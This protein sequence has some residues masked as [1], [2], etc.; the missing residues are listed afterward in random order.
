MKIAP[1]L[2]MIA[3]VAAAQDVLVVDPLGS[4]D[5]LTIASAYAA[6]SPGDVLLVRGGTY[7]G[8][9]IDR[10]VTIVAEEGTSVSWSGPVHVVADQRVVLS[11]LTFL[12]GLE[13]SDTTAGVRVQESQLLVT[14][15]SGQEAARVVRS[16]DV[17]FTRCS[18]LG[19][20]G[21]T[22]SGSDGDGEEGGEGLRVVGP[23]ARVGLY[24]CT[25][26]GG[27]GGD[28]GPGGL[29]ASALGGYGGA[30][31]QVFNGAELYAMGGEVIGG[32][33][34][35][36]F[37]GGE[38]GPGGV[39]LAVLGD[40]AHV[41]NTWLEG[42]SGGAHDPP[43][44][45]AADGAAHEGPIDFLGTQRREILAPRLVRAGETSTWTLVGRPGDVASSRPRSSRSGAT[46][47]WR[48]ASRPSSSPS[49]TCSCRSA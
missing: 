14:S 22:G 35:T 20:E 11:G 4:G 3:P 12:E 2:L 48:R 42:G 43:G 46:W 27:R 21:A 37:M 30:G 38:G 13:V 17:L 39:G 15:A 26:Q 47:S 31:G 45:N 16:R 18:L 49:S 29:F 6:A 7:P 28:G 40:L 24:S 34:G 33:G 9:D 36:G 8:L 5:H 41:T 10:G 44:G 25:L 23:G 32:D 1:C 19:S